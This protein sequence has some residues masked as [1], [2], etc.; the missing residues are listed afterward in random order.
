MSHHG[1][2]PQS[3]CAPHWAAAALWLGL[4][5][6]P[7]G[8]EARAAQEASVRLVRVKAVA[9]EAFRGK[10]RWRNEIVDHIAWS[11]EKLRELARIGL[12]LVAVESWETHGSNEM[13]LLLDSLRVGVD[14]GQADVVV[15]FTGHAPPVYTALVG[16]EVVRVSPTYTAGVAL[17]MGDRAVVRRTQWKRDV[18]FVLIHE[19]AH[20]FGGLHV[21]E[22]SILETGGRRSSFTLDPFNARVLALTRF[23]DFD[24]SF[25][26]LSPDELAP[27]VELY[28]EAPL[29]NENDADTAVRIAYIS[30]LSGDV[31]TA[32]REFRRALEIDPGASGEVLRNAVIPQLESWKERSKPTIES[33]LLLGEA[34]LLTGRYP[35]AIFELS[36]SCQEVEPHPPSCAVLGSALF[37]AG[38]LAG[39]EAALTLAL[40]H[41]DTLARAFDALAGV[42]GSR[43][44]YDR[45]LELFDR[46]LELDPAN[47]ETHFNRGLTSLLAG[48]P[49]AAEASFR[50]VLRRQEGAERAVAK[51]GVALARQ[52]KTKE[53]RR[54]IRPL[55]DE[56]VLSAF[57]LR[58]M[59]EVYMLAGD[60][61]KAFEHI[62][63]AKKGG[64]DVSAVE[65]A[66]RQGARRPRQP[67]TDDLIEQATAYFRTGDGE[68]ARALLGQAVEREPRN[69]DVHYWLGRVAGRDGHEGEAARHYARALELDSDHALT[70]RQ[71]GR[72]AYLEGDWAGA[73]AHLEAYA[74]D[75]DRPASDSLYMLGRSHFE[76]GD[77]GRAETRLLEAIRRR[78]SYGSA[79]YFLGLIHLERGQL[80]A[81]RRDFNLALDSR[82]LPARRRGRAHYE[83]ARLDE[84]DGRTHEALVHARQAV[85]LGHAEADVL[86][87]ELERGGSGGAS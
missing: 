44:D 87:E 48:R 22:K 20:L 68:T 84:R 39:A 66:I 75:A 37:K 78:S 18:R 34:Y 65:I 45:A 33:R 58:D 24:R 19:V 43:G 51:L 52:G 1:V 85:A 11:D 63:L 35:S 49:G 42:H 15:G 10:K 12:D 73:I 56:S 47:V 60:E 2:V 32:T 55:E 23:R 83:L 9:D 62:Q 41:D 54:A 40:R 14:K 4:L 61:K 53:A 26:E 38:D 16:G 59:A 46:A 79:F 64:I 67:S 80:E 7:A 57:S 71:L 29:K 5:V 50:E 31:D 72:L 25:G 3:R 27:L 81:A 70:L 17:P 86:L 36:P 82:S 74:S 28:R 6:T 13:G 8:A 77:L 21:A 76:R 30:L 69:P